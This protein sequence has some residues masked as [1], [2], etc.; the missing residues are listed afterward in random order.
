MRLGVDK[1]SKMTETRNKLESVKIPLTDEVAALL[2]WWPHQQSSR[3]TEV[4]CDLQPQ[5]SVSFDRTVG[6]R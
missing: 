4:E 1:K 5:R 2:T 6:K 3:Q